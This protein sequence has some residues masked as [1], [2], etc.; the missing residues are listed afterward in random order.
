MPSRCRGLRPRRQI[1][2]FRRDYCWIIRSRRLPP[3]TFPIPKPVSPVRDAAPPFERRELYRCKS[4]LTGAL[5]GFQF[6]PPVF[7]ASSAISF[8]L[9]RCPTPTSKD[10]RYWRR[11]RKSQFD[12]I[13]HDWLLAHVPTD[14]TILQKWLKSGYMDKHV[15]HETTKGTPQS[16]IMVSKHPTCLKQ[17]H[18]ESETDQVRSNNNKHQV[19]VAD[20]HAEILT[21]SADHGSD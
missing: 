17:P 7:L 16:G 12:Q 21:E 11:I 20:Y 9:G 1:P 4:G 18:L 8:C 15:L 19:V 14:R 3:P 2:H 5:Q 10:P 13:S 6:V